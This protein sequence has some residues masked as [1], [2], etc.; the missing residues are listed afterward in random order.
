[1]TRQEFGLF[2]SALKT[3]YSKETNLLPNQQAMELWFRELQDIP[4]PVAEAALRKWVNTNKWSPSI[5][6]IREITVNIV[7]GDQL[8]WGE[9]W[10]RFKGAV[11]KYGHAN[12]KEALESLDPMTRRVAECFGYREFCMSDVSTEQT[13]RAQFR[14]IF[15]TLEKRE[16]AHKQL[17]LPLQQTINQIQE[18]GL[19]RLGDGGF[20]IC[21]SITD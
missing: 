3:Y 18:G 12:E 2:V 20:G 15:E 13:S 9:S 5:A 19:M 21:R 10:E 11:R 4:F 7:A 17:P 16:K 6:E 8:T 14:Q 1:M